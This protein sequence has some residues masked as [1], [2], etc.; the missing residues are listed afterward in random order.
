MLETAEGRWLKGEDHPL[1]TLWSLIPA[2]TAGAAK[3]GALSSAADYTFIGHLN[4]T[5]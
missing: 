4:S 5:K 3:R 1:A 2:C